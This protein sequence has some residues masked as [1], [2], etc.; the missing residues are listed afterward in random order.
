L[1][2]HIKCFFL[3]QGIQSHG[4]FQSIIPSFEHIIVSLLY[5]IIMN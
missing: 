1:N 5:I 4:V 2:E 3:C